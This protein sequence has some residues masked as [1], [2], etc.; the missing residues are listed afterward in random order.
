MAGKRC[1][2]SPITYIDTAEGWLYLA[3]VLDMYARPIVG[4]SMADHMQAT[5]VEQA[6]LLALG[7]RLPDPG[8]LHHSDQG[9]QFTSNLIQSLLA[10]HHIQVSMSDVGNGY[11]N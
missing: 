6:L 2:A 10:K 11:T 5:M 9:S 8:L 7:R 1:V 4:W 3:A